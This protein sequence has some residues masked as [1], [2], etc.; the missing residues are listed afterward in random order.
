MNS[1]ILK[2][3][4]SVLRQHSAEVTSKDDV[5]ALV[6]NLF[7][8]LS[9]E[10]GVG[11]AA[12][13]IGILKQ[14]FII[15]TSSMATDNKAGNLARRVVI[16]PKIIKQ[17]DE[18]N[19]YKEG[20]LS[21]PNIFEEIIRPEK[22]IVRYLDE[23]LNQVEQEFNDIEARVFQHEFDH[24]NGVL[25]IDRMSKLRRSMI[26]GKLKRIARSSKNA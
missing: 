12:P 2:Y 18:A 9:K 24:L 16:N 11:L 21:F 26:A 17:S 19:I 6:H 14:V 10:G 22:I 25:F 5:N 15:V 13:Q 1:K 8:V 7:E 3:G 23:Q 4:S 20:C